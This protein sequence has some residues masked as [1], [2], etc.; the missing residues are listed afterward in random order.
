MEIEFRETKEVEE[1]SNQMEFKLKK[2]VIL[3]V[4]VEEGIRGTCRGIKNLLGVKINENKSGSKI[5]SITVTNCAGWKD[6]DIKNVGEEIKK[7]IKNVF[8]KHKT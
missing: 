5:T 2:P 7:S 1:N 8:E 4:N 6:D 3:K